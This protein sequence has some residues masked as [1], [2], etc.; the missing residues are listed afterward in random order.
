MALVN[1][2]YLLEGRYPELLRVGCGVSRIGGASYEI[3]QGLFQNGA[4][5]G[6]CD[7]VIVNTREGR[8]HTLTEAWKAA[9]ET[10][11][12]GGGEDG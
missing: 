4:C 9:L 12:I 5:I 2:A 10:I 7:T 11:R 6:I 1:I 3:A 8:S